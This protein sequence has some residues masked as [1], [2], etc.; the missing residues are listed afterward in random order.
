IYVPLHLPGRFRAGGPVVRSSPGDVRTVL[1]ALQA[2]DLFQAVAAPKTYPEPRKASAES[3]DPARH[4]GAPAAAPTAPAAS[5]MATN[6]RTQM[7][8]VRQPA[9]AGCPKPR[10][11]RF[12]AFDAAPGH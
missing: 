7:L 4:A 1:L 10:G 3:M 9:P 2:K 12:R 8:L 5:P 11:P 6:R